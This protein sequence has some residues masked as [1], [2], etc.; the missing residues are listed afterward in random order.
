[1]KTKLLLPCIV[2]ALTIAGCIEDRYQWSPNGKSMTVITNDGLRIADADGKLTGVNVP[3]VHLVRWFA[4]SRHLLASKDIDVAKWNDLTAYLT[5]AQIRS[6]T[7]AAQRV[8][9]AILNYNWS[10]GAD[11][12]KFESDYLKGPES[13]KE[14]GPIFHN[15]DSAVGVYLRDHDDGTLR[16]FLP[17]LRWMDL[18]DLKQS[19]HSIAE[20][21]VGE[22]EATWGKPLMTLPQG[23]VDLRISP[24]GR[25]AMI[26]AP[27]EQQD[28]GNG[29]WLVPTDGS[30][31]PVLVSDHAAAHPDWSVDGHYV[32]YVCSAP[33][34]ADLGVLRRARVV[35]DDGSLIA[36][37]PTTEDLA[38]L[39]FN[40]ETRV[41]CLADGR[42]FFNSVEIVLPAAPTDVGQRMELFAV[43]PGRQATVMRLLTATALMQI[44]DS[45]AYF[46]VSPDG[47]HV[48]IP[49]QTGTVDVVN[50]ASG[51]VTRVQSKVFPIPAK[52][53][54]APIIVPTWRNN[55]ELTFVAPGDDGRP[56]VILYSLSSNSGKV[57]SATWPTDIVEELAPK[58]NSN[59]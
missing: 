34:D 9:P 57:L 43:D 55:D 56:Q 21:T 53:D 27:M 11:W 46:E 31:A 1:M 59:H 39:A 13:A 8:R 22:S 58:P 7:D 20:C 52:G 37:Q 14:D 5:A 2:I 15:L 23:P 42:I 30:V 33:H 54:S 4:D 3:G 17:P 48:S 28:Q 24:D 50:L 18:Q 45:A 29:I 40:A 51:S 35:G 19:I 36:K 12:G 10:T 47:L 6:V 44:G 41:R 38:G 25:E 49:D 26:V 16:D 32:V